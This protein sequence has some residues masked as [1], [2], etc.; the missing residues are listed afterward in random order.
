MTPAEE[1]ALLDQLS[2]DVE[3]QVLAAYQR[4]MDLMR[5]GTAPRDAITRAMDSFTGEFAD[6]MAA[7]L[8][9][10][11]Q[12]SVGTESALAIN[13]GPVSLSRKLYAEAQDVSN[14]VAGIVQRNVRGY[15]DSKRLALQ[16]FEGYGFREPDAEPLQ[17]NPENPKL[18]KYMR[19]ILDPDPVRRKMAQAFARIQVD[20]LS[21]PALRA[22]YSQALDAIEDIQGTVGRVELEKTLKTAFYERTRYFAERIARTEA[23]RAY[24]Q[25]EAQILLEDEDVEYVQIRRSRT[26]TAPC[27][28]DLITGRDQYGL[29][30]GVYPKAKAPN[31]PF[32]P[33]CLPG[34]ALITS[35]VNIAAVS[36]RWYDGDMVVITTAT[37]QSV[38]ATVNHPVLTSSGWVAA[39][40]L[41]VG[42][43]VIS[44]VGAESVVGYS[45][46][47][48]Q[49]QHIPAR[50]AEI[51][52][53]FFS[54][55]KVA[56]REVPLTTEHFHGDGIAGK[57]AV[58]GAN[59]KLWDRVNA[60]A[61][62]GMHDSLLVFADGG[63]TRL[64]GDGAFDQGLKAALRASNGVVS[65]CSKCEPLVFGELAHPDDAGFAL[66]PKLDPGLNQ[67]AF[68]DV[69][70]DAELA[71][72]IQ[73][74]STGEV[75]VDN[76]VNVNRFNFSGHVYNL[77][78]EQG[79]YTCN[80]IVT[81]NCKCISSPRLDLSGR[82]AEE[83]ADADQYFLN[84]LSEPIAAKIIGSRDKLARVQ[85][86]ES[87]LAVHNAGSNP[88]YRIVN[89]EQAA[90][91]YSA[92]GPR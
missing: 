12:R 2:D 25:R 44:R 87:A 52:D 26:S 70:A 80:G 13:I 49:H 64:L 55:S 78:T 67:P 91:A 59:R 58:I 35:A 60:L 4:A 84:R 24:S 83:D 28:C 8:S 85:A 72:N 79:H 20:G 23:H 88:V 65:V 42:G 39:G 38:T 33:F 21:T 18:P 76:I 37:G 50:I 9:A 31:P 57:V 32:H 46:I 89:L 27:I 22:A 16:L 82:Q 81:H 61:A 30:R 66:P 71:R 69:A 1:L 6:L 51:A 29:G 43:N 74:G 45:F 56:T 53:A 77:E 3:A 36:K 48:D 17:I 75:L 5:R 14:I 40:L 19:E 34:D 62:Q 63:L 54:S 68:D 47:D 90:N 10:V 86:G 41:N 7:S 73:N 11:L 92:T 15:Q